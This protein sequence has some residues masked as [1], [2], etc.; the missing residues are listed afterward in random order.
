MEYDNFCQYIWK[1]LIHSQ[2]RKIKSE[3]II[4]SCYI[5]V[6]GTINLEEVLE[7]E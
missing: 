5:Y 6:A 1:C 3:D 2:K 7:D 4:S